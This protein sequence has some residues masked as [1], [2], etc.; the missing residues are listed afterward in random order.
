MLSTIDFTKEYRQIPLA[1]EACPKTIFATPSGLYQFTK[2][3]LGLYGATVSFQWVM[4]KALTSIQD[5][6]VAYISKFSP[7]WEPLIKHLRRVLEDLCNAVLTANFKKSKLGRYSVQ[8]LVFCIG[9][10]QIWACLTMSRSYVMLPSR[11][12]KNNCKG[13]WDWLIVT[14]DS[15]PNMPQGW[16]L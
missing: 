3:P 12:P 15:F 11:P 5:C 13:F 2:M 10:G 7:S 1:E 4:V 14:A 9:Q 16:R 8:Y 6:T